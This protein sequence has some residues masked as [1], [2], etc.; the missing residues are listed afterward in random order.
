MG[1][2]TILV[3]F[4]LVGLFAFAMISGGI[5][6]ANTNNAAQNI[7]DDPALS[8][9][10]DSLETALGEAH[11][12]ANAS[13]EAI[14]QSPITLVTGTFIFDAIGGVWKTLKVVP[15]TVYNLTFGLVMGKIF[16]ETFEVVFGVIA[17]ILI[18]LIIFGV[19]KWIISGQED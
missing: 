19:W 9:Y 12:G 11:E 7:G 18:M 14:G 6:L 4:L 10:R 3:S 8:S 2:K 17:A 13:V 16:G 5:M 1:L 15:V